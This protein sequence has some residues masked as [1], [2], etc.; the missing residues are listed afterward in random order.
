MRSSTDRP[1]DMDNVFNN[2]KQGQNKIINISVKMELLM[3]YANEPDILLLI[4]KKIQLLETSLQLINFN[5]TK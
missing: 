5:C 4:S 1:T 2:K 3:V